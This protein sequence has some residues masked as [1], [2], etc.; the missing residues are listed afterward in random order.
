[1][2]AI[3]EQ[4]RETIEQFAARLG[5]QFI[6][7]RIEAR[8]DGIGD[9]G[10]GATHWRITLAR[11]GQKMEF[12]YSMGSA[13]TE[14]PT[15]PDVL[16]CLAMDA[17]DFAGCGISFEDWAGNLGYDTDSR[18]AE[19]IFLATMANATA[20]EKLLGAD[21]LEHLCFNIERL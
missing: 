9:W 7:E 3:T 18:K 6:A 4:N 19:R 21:E 5:V 1:M 17:S 10:E 20:L 12:F 16:D 14:P 15:L 2:E 13:C 8:P 11:N